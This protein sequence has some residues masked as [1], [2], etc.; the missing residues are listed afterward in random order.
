MGDKVEK[1]RTRLRFVAGLVI[2][3]A[4]SILLGELITRLRLPDDLQPFLGEVSSLTG[5]YRPDPDLGADYRSLDDFRAHYAA[6]LKELEEP[7]RPQRVWAWF[8]NSFVQAPD[9]LGDMAQSAVP[10]VRM[11]YLRRNAQLPLHIAHI[12]LL[13]DSGLKPAR[14]IF[15]LLP[16]DTAALGTQP[17]RTMA[18]NSRGAITYRLRPPQPPFDALIRSSRLAMLAWVRSGRHVGNPQFKPKHVTDFVAPELGDD[19]GTIFRILGATCRRHHVPVTVL[20]LPNREQVFGKAGYALQDFVRE[21]CRVEGM[22]CFDLRDLFVQEKDKLSLFL[23][24]WHFT[25]KAN[26]IVLAALLG[27]WKIEPGVGD[28]P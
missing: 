25:T 27:H 9:M 13:L 7:S 2:G 23:P 18:V 17:L 3:F 11:F 20:L 22:D 8:G 10:E 6:R 24:D 16:I 21:R 15:V 5:V 12:R 19:L 14:I 26:R 1:R 4:L 28:A